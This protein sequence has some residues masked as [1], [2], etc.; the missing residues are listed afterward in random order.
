MGSRAFVELAAERRLDVFDMNL[1]QQQQKGFRRA[2]T[3]LRSWSQAI[4]HHAG[5]LRSDRTW[6]RNF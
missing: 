1:D 3:R 4:A 2:G 5:M 6:P